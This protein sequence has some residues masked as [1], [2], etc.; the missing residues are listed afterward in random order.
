MK[1]RPQ[2]GERPN[3]RP[4]FNTQ[5]PDCQSI[6]EVHLIVY[7]HAMR[8]PLLLLLLLALLMSGLAL[9]CRLPAGGI[10]SPPPTITLPPSSPTTAIP[11]SYTPTQTSAPTF[12]PTPTPPPATRITDGDHALFNGDWEAASRAYQAAYDSSSDP[13][14]QSAALLGLGRVDY[15][16][17]DFASALNVLRPLVEDFPDS[18][19]RA[20]AYF[21]LG[22]SYTALSRFLDAADAYQN[23][24]ALRHGA[25]DAYVF[26][27]RG[28]ALFAGGEYGAAL[29]DYQSALQSP[30]LSS[31]LSL[32]IKMART[33]AITGDT[34]TALIMYD[35]IYQRSTNDYQRAHVDY[36]KGQT[37]NSIGQTDSAYTAYLDAVTHF[38]LAYDAYLSLVELVN[39]S[40]PVS[41]LDRGIVDYFAGEYAVAVAALDRYLGGDPADPGT[42]FYYKGLSQRALG[43][44]DNAIYQWDQLIASYPDNSLWD[45]AWE[46]K[47]YTQW[48]YQD[49]YA[50]AVQTLLDFIDAAPTH[51]R[52]DEFLFDAAQ[53]AERSGDLAQA[54]IL[55]ERVALEYPGSDYVFRALFLSGICQYR[56]ANALEAQALLLRAQQISAN[57]SDRVMATFWVAKTYS[58]LGN[59][60]TARSM[61]EQT[62]VMDPTGYYSE[63]ARDL[64]AGRAPFLAP[65]SFDIGIDRAAERAEAETWLRT[66]FNIPSVIDLSGPGSLPEDARFQRGT[67]F[68]RLM[69]FDLASQEFDSLRISVQDDVVATYRLANYLVEL[70]LYRPAILAARRVLDLAGMNDASSL[71]APVY[72]NHI[73]FG[74]YFADLIIPLA[75][76]YQIHP[77]LVWSLIRQESFFEPF[78]R[79]SADARGLMQIIPATGQDIANRMG[80][81][82]DYTTED[83]YRPVVSINMGLDYLSDQ[84]AY[85]DG[86]LYA[87]LSAYNGG[88]GNARLWQAMAPNDP[89]LF[90]EVIRLDEPR[91]YIRAIY[92]IYTIYRR[93]YTHTP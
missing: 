22:Q 51:S 88:P 93:L 66:L 64:L 65:P 15:F 11:P 79:S 76:K 62:V 60:D 35:D 53:I 75:E 39:A 81:P 26:E 13:E 56:L 46:Q 86:D 12:T 6:D 41:E 70:G 30:R 2:F 34:G 23:Y 52:V 80:W 61:W 19:Y 78:A 91:R 17:G 67:E 21:T 68:W 57:V 49:Q 31:D 90:L 71:N 92:E 50:P 5:T 73:R 28:D 7:S 24:L 14:I 48:A 44:T 42:A 63:R 82:A 83:L 3:K 10:G 27:L 72:F 32:E 29:T 40:Y 43:E 37:L 18:T 89:D 69:L 38:P 47:A 8:R 16:S 36:L 87:A 74:T 1:K 55:W 9:A 45:D 4:E 54:S 84:I 85:L 77:L 20:E 58:A 59:A 33:Y 25:I